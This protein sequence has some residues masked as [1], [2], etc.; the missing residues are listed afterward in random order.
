MLQ[1][2][3]QNASCT[4]KNEHRHLSEAMAGI[5]LEKTPNKLN[6]HMGIKTMNTFT[7]QRSKICLDKINK[8][9]RHQLLPETSCDM[10][11]IYR[12]ELDCRHSALLQFYCWFTS[13]WVYRHSKYC[14]GKEKLTRL[15]R[16]FWC[17]WDGPGSSS[18]WTR[19]GS[20]S[21]RVHTALPNPPPHSE[22]THKHILVHAAWARLDFC[23]WD[24][25]WLLSHSLRCVFKVYAELRFHYPRS[26][27]SYSWCC[28]KHMIRFEEY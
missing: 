5:K 28:M 21:E 4:D 17:C 20:F 24:V 2:R 16:T 12:E 25:C 15:R 14:L 1:G 13:S 9:R 23:T 26:W 7:F 22:H 10:T 27:S 3:R 11:S 19:S 6:S 8:T 18:V